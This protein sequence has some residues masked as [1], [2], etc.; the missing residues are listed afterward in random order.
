MTTNHAESWNKAILDA[1]KLLVA[2]LVWVLFQKTVEYF[3]QRRLKIALQVFKGQ[4]FTKYA[5]NLMNHAKKHF[6]GKVFDLGTSSKKILLQSVL[7]CSWTRISQVNES[8]HLG[9]VFAVAHMDIELLTIWRRGHRCHLLNR[10]VKHYFQAQPQPCRDQTSQGHWKEKDT[11]NNIKI[12]KWRL[13]NEDTI[14]LN[15]RELIDQKLF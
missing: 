6:M 10:F 2:S 11:F 7:L 3:D 15:F 4:I 9:I 12:N 5:N 8:F 14:P 1:R 13:V